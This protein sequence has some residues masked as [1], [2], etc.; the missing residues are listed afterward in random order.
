MERLAVLTQ[1]YREGRLT[2]QEYHRERA[3]IVQSLQEK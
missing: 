2:P 3:K 1:L